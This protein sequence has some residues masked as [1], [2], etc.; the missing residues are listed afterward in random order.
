M[1]NAKYIIEKSLI[2]Q[3]IRGTALPIVKWCKKLKNA[4]IKRKNKTQEQ[5]Y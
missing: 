1:Q 3:Q 2:L 5:N 4:G